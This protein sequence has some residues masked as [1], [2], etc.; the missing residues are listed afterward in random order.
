MV[1]LADR[2]PVISILSWI[3]QRL[4]FDLAK[5]MRLTGPENKNTLFRDSSATDQSPRI[6]QG[7]WAVRDGKLSCHD[8]G[9]HGTRNTVVCSSRS[10]KQNYSL[11]SIIW[12]QYWWWQQRSSGRLTNKS[13]LWKNESSLDENNEIQNSAK[14]EKAFYE[15][16]C[17]AMKKTMVR[18]M[19]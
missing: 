12:M 10:W 2:Y 7:S 15:F 17:S 11:W 5:A 8:L 4:C 13:L 16:F 9:H 19:K 1:R 6:L 18:K 3:H 14:N